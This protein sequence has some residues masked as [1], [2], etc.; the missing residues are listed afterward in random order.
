MNAEEVEPVTI[1]KVPPRYANE[2]ESC[3]IVPGSE[4]GN[5]YDG[6]PSRSDC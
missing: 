3:V 4:R 2:G 6:T 1:Y 5:A